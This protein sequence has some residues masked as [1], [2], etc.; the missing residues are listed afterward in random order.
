MTTH[1]SM[2]SDELF[3]ALG[4]KS[5]DGRFV[6]K[7]EI[8]TTGFGPVELVLHEHILDDAGKK[9]SEE[10]SH[11]RLVKRDETEGTRVTDAVSGR[12]LGPAD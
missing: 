10:L 5:R 2:M 3:R 7:I 8:T 12:D 9:L 1:R 4:L 11:F 6:H